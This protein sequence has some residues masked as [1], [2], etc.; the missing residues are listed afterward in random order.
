[1]NSKLKVDD[2]MWPLL[3]IDIDT[4]DFDMLEFVNDLTVF[5]SKSQKFYVIIH[6]GIDKLTSDQVSKGIA[7]LNIMYPLINKLVS[8]VIVSGVSMYA[9]EILKILPNIC[10][11]VEFVKSKKDALSHF[12]KL[13]L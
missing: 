8:K 12:E 1:M 10:K 4:R 7:W 2:S 9:Q 5:F 11:N 13:K 6:F 3:V